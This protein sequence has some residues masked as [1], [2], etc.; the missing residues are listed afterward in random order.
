M[1]EMF[2]CGFGIEGAGGAFDDV[3]PAGGV[4]DALDFA[5]GRGPFAA[6]HGVWVVVYGLKMVWFC[7][8]GVGRERNR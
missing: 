5:L 2:V 7:V 6:G 8:G 3:G 4:G 1:F